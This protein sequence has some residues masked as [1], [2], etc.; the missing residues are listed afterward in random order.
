MK[1]WIGIRTEIDEDTKES[2]DEVVEISLFKNQNDKDIY[3]IDRYKRFS[4]GSRTSDVCQHT[5]TYSLSAA[6]RCAF[7]D[8]GYK[9]RDFKWDILE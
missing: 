4:D 8:E 1:K 6:K 9:S 2:Y 3:N 7:Q 5:F